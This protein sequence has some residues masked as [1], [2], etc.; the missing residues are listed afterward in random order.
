MSLTIRERNDLEVLHRICGIQFIRYDCDEDKFFAKQMRGLKN[1]IK[2]HPEDFP[3][4]EKQA[5]SVDELL[6]GD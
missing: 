4:L 2:F 6:K 5:Y 3:S 1:F